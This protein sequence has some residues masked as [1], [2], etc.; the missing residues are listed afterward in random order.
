MTTSRP[1]TG[2]FAETFELVGAALDKWLASE[3]LDPLRSPTDW[4]A[5][6]SGP[7]PQQGIGADATLEEFTSLVLPHGPHLTSDASW[8]WITTGPSTV[9]TAITAAS[10]IASPQRQTL[11]AFN[12]LEEQALDWLAEMCGL[13]SHMKGVFSSGGS[14][15]NLVALGAARQ[16]ALEQQGFDPSGDGFDATNVAMYTSDQAH[17][18]VQR[19]AGVLGIGRSKVRS[20]PTDDQM[21]MD[22]NALEA[23]LKRDQADGV[24]PVAVVVAAGTTNT[25]SIDPIRRAGE[26]AKEYGA[27]FHVDGAYGLPGI[28]DDRVAP[29]YDGMELADSTITDPHKWLNVPVGVAA[30]FVRDRS[31]L[32]R[33]FTQEPADYLE[34]AFSA[35]DVQ[36]SLDD[37]GIPY[38]DFGVELSSPVR[39]VAV[40]GV[41][42]ELGVDGVRSRVIQDNDFARHVAARAREHPRLETLLDPVLSICV[43]RYVPAEASEAQVD[44]VN[45]EI[46]RLLARE[47]RFVVS[48]TVVKGQFALRPCFI[49]PRT[50]IAD[51]DDFVDTVLAFGERAQ[52]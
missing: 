39:G 23:A 19:S 32:Y 51:V 30:T 42:K 37:M 44:A 45:R 16:W 35:D 12:L 2:R 49:N 13:D 25:G 3:R 47:S 46:L 50:T 20:I 11:T 31:I 41:L 4:R 28:L 43:F 22:V 5:E 48:S 10:M 1:E 24:L 6:L 21:R 15:A 26:L 9:P 8:G 7:V 27:W 36:V 34:G 17:H 52:G 29:L 38:F 14:T 33:A 40:W 18:T